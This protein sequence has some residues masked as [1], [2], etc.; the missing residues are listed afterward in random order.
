[1]TSTTA[2]NLRT[3]SLAIAGIIL[4]IA[5]AALPIAR[6][7]SPGTDIPARIGREAVWW[8]IGA[9][10]IAWVVAV[11]KLPLASIGLKP[12]TWRTFAWGIAGALA[13]IAT[14]MLSYAVIF[15]AFGLKMNMAAVDAVTKVPIWLMLATMLRAGVVEEII[16]RGYAIERLEALTGNKWLAATV[17]ALAFIAIHVSGWGFA[18]LIVVTFGAILLS[19]LYLWRRDLLCNIIA[20]TLV[21]IIG[22]TLARVQGG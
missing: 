16:F 18:Q 4:L 19:L 7:L 5:L 21:D 3:R 2:P 8:G 17:S 10:A 22:F 14:V 15:P 6:W 1:M 11:E 9:I 20:H 13:M 12:P